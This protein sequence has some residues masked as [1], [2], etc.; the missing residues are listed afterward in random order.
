M[1][2]GVGLLTVVAPLARDL[3]GSSPST[4][5]PSTTWRSVTARRRSP[6][7]KRPASQGQPDTTAPAG[8]DALPVPAP[9]GAKTDG[10][11]TDETLVRE[12]LE[13]RSPGASAAG[14][15]PFRELVTRYE[16][17]AYWIAKGLVHHPEDAK[18]VAQEAFV[19][20]F[21]SL[22]KFDPNLKFYTWFYQ[23]VV[24]LAI[25]H[26]RRVKKRP[27]VSLDE[28]G[29]TG[30]EP[31]GPSEQPGESVERDEAKDRVARVL[32]ELPEKYRSIIV[33]RD[34]EGFDGKEVA[35]IAGATHATVR[36]R[37]HKARQMFKAAWEKIYGAHP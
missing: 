1:T 20:V 25:D 13:A 21:K 29:E 27:K 22:D 28:L 2:I 35:T 26:L 17:R 36:W 4:A 23:I 5:S 6:L 12:C 19:R 37:L 34:L 18:D 10:A 11:K 32:L 30:G 24:N 31:A 33:L 16:E 7:P 8:P 15:A 9:P 3:I 14:E